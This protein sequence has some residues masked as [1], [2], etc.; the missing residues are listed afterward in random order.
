[1]PALWAPGAATHVF[2]LF[3]GEGVGVLWLIPFVFKITCKLETKQTCGYHDTS[4]G[5]PLPPSLGAVAQISKALSFII[6][7]PPQMSFTNTHTHTHT[8]THTF[9]ESTEESMTNHEGR[10]WLDLAVMVSGFGGWVGEEGREKLSHVCK[11]IIWICLLNT[12]HHIN[13]TAMNHKCANLQLV[14]YKYTSRD[15]LNGKVSSL[16]TQKDSL[17]RGPAQ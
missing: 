8:H 16:Q 6:S 2:Y 9:F 1:M 13:V 14:K 4:N 15:A 17:Q 10:L 11:A 3:F 5:A 12:S 7:F